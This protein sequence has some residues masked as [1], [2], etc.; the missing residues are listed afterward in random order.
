MLCTGEV[1][2]NKVKLTFVKGAALE[3]PQGLFNASLAGNARRAIDLHQD[4]KLDGVAFKSLIRAA[5]GK[6]QSR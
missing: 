3:D 4:D 1:Y 5:A 2:K 6:N